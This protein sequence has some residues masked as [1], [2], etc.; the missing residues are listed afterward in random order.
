MGFC[1]RTLFLGFWS[2]EVILL[3][4]ETGGWVFS[5][6]SGP[7]ISTHHRP[8]HS[9]SLWK[10]R[11]EQKGITVLIQM[12]SECLIVNKLTRERDMIN[13]SEDVEG[14]NPSCP[15]RTGIDDVDTPYMHMFT[16]W[17]GSFR[18]N[19]TCTRLFFFEAVDQPQ[20]RDVVPPF[21]LIAM[22]HRPL[23]PPC[24]NDVVCSSVSSCF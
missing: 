21:W 2:S 1:F 12:W 19:Y 13:M 15:W 18:W 17:N 24:R 4:K 23:G 16:W 5:G 7:N 20:R 14:C 10:F 22:G 6:C 3:G 9:S 8:S 11:L